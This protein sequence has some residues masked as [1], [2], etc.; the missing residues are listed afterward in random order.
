MPFYLP[1]LKTERTDSASYT[2][3]KMAVLEFFLYIFA[4]SDSTQTIVFR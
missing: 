3:I 1:G 4:L 2:Y